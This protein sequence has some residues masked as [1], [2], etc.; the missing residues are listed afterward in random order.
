MKQVAR[1]ALVAL[2]ICL[3]TAI[4]S[5]HAA[6]GPTAPKAR[7]ASAASAICAPFHRLIGMAQTGRQAPGGP[8][9]SSIPARKFT[10]KDA[11]L[12]AQECNA[13]AGASPGNFT[14]TCN[15]TPADAASAIQLMKQRAAVVE[16]CL[17]GW[18][19]LSWAGGTGFDRGDGRLILMIAVPHANFDDPMV[20]TTASYERKPDISAMAT[21][22][23]TMA[24]MQGVVARNLAGV[25]T[26]KVG[27]VSLLKT[28]LAGASLCLSQTKADGRKTAALACKWEIMSLDPQGPDQEAIARATY[29]RWIELTDACR[30]GQKQMAS[31]LPLGAGVVSRYTSGDPLYNERWSI[32][33]HEPAGRNP[34]KLQVMSIM[35]DVS[36]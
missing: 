2:A 19:K 14:A 31:T 23:D 32:T 4:P 35:R 18:R 12:G 29:D 33:L 11:Q 9:L 28:P 5:V 15:N 30:A 34:W 21:N 27:N 17:P 8:V 16:I 13:W 24:K 1:S 25:A 3:S 26:T 22:C 6:D 7:I 10:F 36:R 20:H